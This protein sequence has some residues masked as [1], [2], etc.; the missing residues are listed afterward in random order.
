[1]GWVF[2]TERALCGVGEN[3]ELLW[4]QHGSPFKKP[5]LIEDINFL[6]LFLYSEIN[7]I[8]KSTLINILLYLK[9]QNYYS[10]FRNY[11]GVNG[12]KF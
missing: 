4:G 5:H 11:P 6:A 1:M 12:K 7:I 8:H 2:I 9:I 10:K 3:Y